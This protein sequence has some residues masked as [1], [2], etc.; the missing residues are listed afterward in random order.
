MKQ[1]TINIPDKKIDFFLELL[2][3]MGLTASET[4][5]NISSEA[6]K[7]ILDRIKTAEE[8]DYVDWKTARKHLKSG[9]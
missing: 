5:L 8:S 9:K 1:L 7:I 3:S 4:K 6:K 2:E